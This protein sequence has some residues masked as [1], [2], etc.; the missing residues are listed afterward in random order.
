M[1]HYQHAYMHPYMQYNQ[2]PYQQSYPTMPMQTQYPTY[3]QMEMPMQGQMPMYDPVKM[4]TL[5]AIE[6]YVNHGLN[7][8]K[9]TSIAHA[10]KEVAAMSY[11][12]GKGMEPHAAYKLVESWEINEKL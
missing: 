8:A 12:Y 9:K 1:N 3:G 6:E 5:D 11:L 7:E 2:N 4:Q 10:M